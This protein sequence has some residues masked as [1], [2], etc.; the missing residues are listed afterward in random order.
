MRRILFVVCAVTLGLLVARFTAAESKQIK[1]PR[2][3]IV[4]LDRKGCM[5]PCPVY[6]LTVWADGSVLYVGKKNVAVAGRQ[7]KTIPFSQ[8]GELVAA[9]DAANFQK[10]TED[11]SSLQCD[12]SISDAPEIEISI[13]RNSSTYAVTH[14]SDCYADPFFHPVERLAD[15]IDRIVGTKEWVGAPEE[16]RISR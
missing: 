16:E 12:T 3:M 1:V 2:D 10:I 6:K 14:G 4:V 7:E 13:Q 8:I 15:S 9:F 11:A 5:G